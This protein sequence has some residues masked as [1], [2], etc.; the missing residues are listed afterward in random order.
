[1]AK[2]LRL[3]LV[4]LL[5][6]TAMVASEPA[7]AQ[8]S[9]GSSSQTQ[10]ARTPRT[11]RTP[12]RS[13]PRDDK[14]CQDFKTQPEAQAFFKAQGAGDPHRLDPDNDGIAC[15]QLPRGG[16]KKNGLPETGSDA[17]RVGFTGSAFL[18]AGLAFL[19]SARRRTT[20]VQVAAP[21]TMPPAPTE[22]PDDEPLIGW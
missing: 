9:T 2:V 16:G 15:E 18:A 14:D 8:T 13:I 11:P 22:P 17:Q 10:T 21:A 5:V 20:A 1:M 3:L 19:L 6:F 7:D 12:R 4:P